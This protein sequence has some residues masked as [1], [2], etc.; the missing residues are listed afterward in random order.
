MYMPAIS[1]ILIFVSI[2]FLALAVLFQQFTIYQ[3][4]KYY[5]KTNTQTRDAFTADIFEIKARQRTDYAEID[6]RLRS[7]E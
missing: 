1:I 7:L 5:S 2:L 3:Q 6:E 4:T